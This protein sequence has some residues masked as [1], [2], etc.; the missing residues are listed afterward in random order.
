MS[1]WGIWSNRFA[2]LLAC[3]SALACALVVQAALQ[4]RKVRVAMLALGMTWG[5]SAVMLAQAHGTKLDQMALVPSIVGGLKTLP[6]PPAGMLDIQAT[7]AQR[8]LFAEMH[9]PNWFAYRAWAKRQWMTVLY[10]DDGASERI[11]RDLAERHYIIRAGNPLRAGVYLADEYPG[12]VCQT[13]VSMQL[14]A[15]DRWD[16]LLLA[17]H[18]RDA[19]PAAAAKLRK[20]DCPPLRLPAASKSFA[21]MR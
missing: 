18:R 16:M 2:L 7:P 11:V 8:F 12:P 15:V 1:P 5:S 17:G 21:E 14:P 19:I 10:Y 3:V 20:S 13:L 4:R 6:V 9:E